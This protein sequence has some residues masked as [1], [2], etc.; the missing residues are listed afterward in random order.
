M[1][2][3][4]TLKAVLFDLDGTL[5]DTAP[6]M[7]AALNLLCEQES[8]QTLPYELARAHVSNGSLGLLRVAF[9]AEPVAPN[10]PLV[11]RF[12]ELYAAMIDRTTVLFPG[13]AELLETLEHNAIAWGV[14][15]NKPAHLT[16]PLLEGLD[17]RRRCQCVVSGDTLPERKPHP[18]PLLHAL[19]QLGCTAPQALYVG[20]AR[21]DVEA[22]A[23]AGLSTVAA[24]YGYIPPGEDPADWDA[25][26]LIDQPGD[27]LPILV[28]Y[29]M[30]SP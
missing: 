3:E 13:M 16:E 26:H 25:D 24:T 12:L 14:V 8:R 18:A 11:M 20:D 29:G 6:D 23:A 15:T 17:L 4:T 5:L 30:R 1:S 9:G 28:E 7:V 19:A 22:G 10:S 2:R 27:L 21:R